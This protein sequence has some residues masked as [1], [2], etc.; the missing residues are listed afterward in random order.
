M[1]L[2]KIHEIKLPQKFKILQ[3][4]VYS[5]TKLKFAKL[6]CCKTWQLQLLPQI[7]L[8]INVLQPFF[9]KKFKTYRF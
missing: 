2:N 5:E 4:V 1:R 9:G 3:N 6:S 7:V 8:M